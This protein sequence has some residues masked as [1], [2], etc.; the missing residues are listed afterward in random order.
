MKI[1]IKIKKP[2]SKCQRAWNIKTP[3][4]DRFRTISI[5]NETKMVLSVKSEQIVPRP[6]LYF[7]RR[8]VSYLIKTLNHLSSVHKLIFIL[9]SKREVILVLSVWDE[10]GRMV[11]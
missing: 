10:L 11:P 9:S 7:F 6:F 8:R 1:F 3:L 2:F 5:N 4:L